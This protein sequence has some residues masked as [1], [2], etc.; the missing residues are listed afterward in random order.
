M[1][2][3]VVYGRAAR[4]FEDLREFQ[5][6]FARRKPAGLLGGVSLA[7]RLRVSSLRASPGLSSRAP[8]VAVCARAVPGLADRGYDSPQ[9]EDTADRVVLGGVSGRHRQAGVVGAPAPAAT[10]FDP[11]RDRMDVAAQAPARDGERRS[12]ALAWR[13]GDG[14]HLGGWPTTRAPRQPPAE[15]AESGV[16][17]CGSGKTRGCVGPS[18][19]GGALGPQGGDRPWPL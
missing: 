5:R 18:P 11:L 2:L 15:G 19:D 14:R 10:G 9:Y 7:R 4:R 12:R 13:R 17:A 8:T 1:P 3:F 6:Q 16:G